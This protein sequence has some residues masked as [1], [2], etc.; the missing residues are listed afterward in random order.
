V[1]LTK[2]GRVI[3]GPCIWYVRQPSQFFDKTLA[4][5]GIVLVLE[6]E[7][8]AGFGRNGRPQFWFGP[9]EN[10]PEP[11]HV[12]FAAENRAQVRET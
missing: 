11:I 8:W 2:V 5:P 12:A 4:P 6:V 9:G 1:A 3:E 10:P 7:G